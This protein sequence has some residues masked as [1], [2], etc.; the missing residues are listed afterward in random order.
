MSNYLSINFDHLHEAANNVETLQAILSDAYGIQLSKWRKS[1]NSYHVQGVH[2]LN[3]YSKDS[4]FFVKD[5]SGATI[6]SDAVTNA[7]GL[8]KLAYGL[9]GKEAAEKLTKFTGKNLEYVEGYRPQT[10]DSTPPTQSFTLPNTGESKKYYD[11]VE[12]CDF[13]SD[14]GKAVL[15]YCINKTKADEPFIKQF[16][17]P[18]IATTKDQK[19]TVYDANRLAFAVIEGQQSKIF[20]P[21][22]KSIKSDKLPLSMGKNWL[23]GFSNLPL[24]CEYIFLLGGENDTISFNCAFNRF[25]WYAL[26]KG[27]EGYGYDPQLIKLLKAR[28]KAVFSLFDNDY[29]GRENMEKNTKKHGLQ[30]IDLATY[31]N[32]PLVFQDCNFDEFN[33]N[34]TVNDVCDFVHYLGTETLKKVIKAEIRTKKAESVLSYRPAFSSVWKAETDTYLGNLPSEYILLKEYILQGKKVVIKSQTGTGKTTF[35]LEKLPKDTDFLNKNGI[36]RIVY[37]THTN[38]IGEQQAKKQGIPFLTSLYKENSDEINHSKVIAATFDQAHK[39]PQYWLN[40]TLFVCDEIH[41]LQSE[42]GYRQK[43]MRDVLDLLK[44]SKYFIGISATPSLEFIKQFNLDYCI[45][46]YTDNSKAQKINLHITGINKGS[47]KD[48]LN[49]ISSK[50]DNSK[51]TVIFH[52]NITELQAFESE[53][54]RIYGENS[55]SVISSKKDEYYTK[56][57]EYQSLNNTGK[58]SDETKFI[59]TTKFLETGVNFDFEAEIFCIYPESTNSLLQ[60]VARPRFDRTTGVNSLI[61]CFVYVSLIDKSKSEIEAIKTRFEAFSEG[62]GYDVPSEALTHLSDLK[63]AFG[64]AETISQACNLLKVVGDNETAQRQASHNF[65]VFF[66]EKSKLYEVDELGILSKAETNLQGILKKDVISFLGEIQAFNENVAIQ[67]FKIID[68]K[69]DKGLRNTFE[70][71]KIDREQKVLTISQNLSD[72][73]TQND[74]LLV[75]YSESHTKTSKTEIEKLLQYIP[76][77]IDIEAAKNRLKPHFVGIDG[78]EVCEVTAK[79]LG[80]LEAA[81][82]VQYANG[83]RPI[84]KQDVDN[85]LID[86]IQDYDLT[87][88]RLIRLADRLGYERGEKEF[89]NVLNFNSGKISYEIRKR[90]FEATT[91]N[92]RKNPFLNK[93]QMT[94]IYNDAQRSVYLENGSKKAPTEKNFNTIRQ[95]FL[96]LFNVETKRTKAGFI[97]KIGNEITAKNAIVVS[98]IT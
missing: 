53:I 2:G 1:G 24:Q 92:H 60:G 62:K 75:A 8:V 82:G 10:A 25:G 73:T 51:K 71:I 64:N 35:F 83:I 86:I 37:L 88:R 67:G 69:K 40:N 15:A 7:F 18:I 41:T 89:K 77:K 48:L 47:A 95:T 30:G 26:T 65:N 45:A 36:E 87:Q 19:R 34:L 43:T 27:G 96:E 56:N 12:Y 46:N 39:I 66:N 79:Y 42:Y 68:L 3:I 93:A 38:S 94:T 54:K 55:V 63:T 98:K 11:S 4:N 23:F 9:T 29:T 70:N 6:G 91:K 13:S 17:R 14:Y 22:L 72:T 90:V 49:D 21:Y 50:R 31:I 28:C 20:R 32:D 78:G 61:N 44:R 76:N 16:Y 81:K 74:V 85:N 84:S 33:I 5:F 80:I 57:I 97:Y 52:D 58:V 59:L